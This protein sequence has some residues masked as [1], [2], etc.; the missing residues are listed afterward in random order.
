[1]VFCGTVEICWF[2]SLNIIDDPANDMAA[3]SIS[4]LNNVINGLK[5]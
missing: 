3:I 1:V 2:V 5:E 4:H